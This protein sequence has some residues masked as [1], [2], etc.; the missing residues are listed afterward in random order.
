MNKLC[1]SYVCITHSRRRKITKS[2][3][4]MVLA[5]IQ[6][7]C[8]I[9]LSGYS[10]KRMYFCETIENLYGTGNT[11]KMHEHANDHILKHTFYKP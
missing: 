1:L 10:K 8:D 2:P 6:S 9:L 7:K 11:H 4:I 3:F 5:K